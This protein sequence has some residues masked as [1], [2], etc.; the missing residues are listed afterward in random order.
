MPE[1]SARSRRKFLKSLSRTA[2]VLSFQDVLSLAIPAQ[3]SDATRPAYSVP[4]RLG[5]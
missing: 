4:S 2:L 5:A 3:Q 1:D